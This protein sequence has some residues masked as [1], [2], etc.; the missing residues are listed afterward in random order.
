MSIYSADMVSLEPLASEVKMTWVEAD[1]LVGDEMV[2]PLDV[3]LAVV[4]FRFSSASLF[5]SAFSR[6]PLI[7]CVT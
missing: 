3:E 7:T 1:T 5:P 6:G 4:N 2:V